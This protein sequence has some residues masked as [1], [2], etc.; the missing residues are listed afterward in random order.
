MIQ[1]TPGQCKG[2][3]KPVLTDDC[4]GG[5]GD[6]LRKVYSGDSNL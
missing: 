5:A 4:A 6:P 3:R 2:N 1:I